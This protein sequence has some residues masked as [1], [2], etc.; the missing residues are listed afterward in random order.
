MLQAVQRLEC[1]DALAA[2]LAVATEMDQAQGE[3]SRDDLFGRERVPAKSE[4]AARDAPEAIRST[5]VRIDRRPRGQQ[6]FVLGNGQSWEELEPGR[7]RHAV[8]GAVGIERTKLGGYVLSS[9]TGGA[10]RVRRIE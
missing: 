9:R 2:S 10:T 4:P 6:V 7:A 8:G 5:I 3:A 1:F